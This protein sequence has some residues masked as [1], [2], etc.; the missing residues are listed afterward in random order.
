MQN[1]M[2]PEQALEIIDRVLSRVQDT[3]EGH[4]V[5]KMALAIINE[6]IKPKVKITGETK[7][8]GSKAA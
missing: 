3:R 2:T 6:A 8:D 4:E 5:M 7:E 1:Q